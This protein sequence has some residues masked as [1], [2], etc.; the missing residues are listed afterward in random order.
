MNVSLAFKEEKVAVSKI[1][2]NV[3]NV[4]ILTSNASA[5]ARVRW[6]E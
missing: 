5:Y 2:I 3:M 1:Q 6:K 4:R